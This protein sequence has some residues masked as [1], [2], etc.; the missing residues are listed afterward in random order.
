MGGCLLREPADVL[1]TK[2]ADPAKLAVY[3]L[4]SSLSDAGMVPPQVATPFVPVTVEQTSSSASSV[5][6]VKN[7]TV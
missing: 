7:A 6:R 4:S 2:F 3:V 5:D 1:D